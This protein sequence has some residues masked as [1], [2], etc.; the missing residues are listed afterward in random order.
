MSLFEANKTYKPFSYPWAMDLA[1]HHEKIH[2][3][4][5]EAD[6]SEDLKDWKSNKIGPADK[7]FITQVLRLFTQM[8]SQVANNYI[9]YLLPKFK[10][11]E[12]RNMYLSFGN[13]EGEHQRAYALLNDTLGLPDS[14]YSKFLEYKEMSDKI[15]FMQDVDVH[16]ISGTVLALANMILSEGVSVFGPFAM[17]LNYQNK[18]YG[19]MKGMCTVVEWSIRD[20]SEHVKGHSLVFRQVIKE[21]P[22]VVTDELKAKI[23]DMARKVY[24]LESKFIDLAYREGGP[25]NLKKEDVKQYIRYLIDRRLIQMGLKGNF[26]EKK[27]PLKWLDWTVSGASLDNFFEKKVTEYSQEGLLGSS[28]GYEKAFTN[29]RKQ[30]G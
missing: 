4:R 2:W 15:D 20:E 19:I 27:N 13:R 9:D 3:G 28:W 23:Y 18:P 24:E 30:N 21:H 7:D 22:R 5:W 16:S 26:N 29:W 10:N 14:E 25:S 11:N 12:I 8:D 17:L 1:E 6:L